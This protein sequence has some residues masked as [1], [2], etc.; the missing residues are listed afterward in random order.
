MSTTKLRGT[1]SGTVE[2][3]EYLLEYSATVTGDYYFQKGRMYMPNG[4]PGYPD[5]EDTEGPFLDEI[6]EVNIMD[7]NGNYIEE[8]EADHIY[9]TY[10]EEIDKAIEE[11]IEE[12]VDWDDCDWED[13]E[14]DY[15]EE[16]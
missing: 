11:E 14:P 9:E 13:P 6:Q 16:E 3:D 15:P 7:I 1:V 2:W 12:R 10:Q 5:E 8:S 4:D